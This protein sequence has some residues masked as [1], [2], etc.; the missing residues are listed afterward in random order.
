MNFRYEATSASLAFITRMLVRFPHVQR[1][2]RTGLIEATEGGK[3]FEVERLDRFSYLGAVIQE[4]LRMYTP[5]Y[6]Y[7]IFLLRL[8]VMRYSQLL[9]KL[10]YVTYVF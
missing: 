1:R 2:L 8:T 5:I 4:C 10:L 7:V 9:V 6:A 3:R